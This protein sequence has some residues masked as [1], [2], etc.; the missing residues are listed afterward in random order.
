MSG[1]PAHNACLRWTCRADL[2]V[3]AQTDQATPRSEDQLNSLWSR[4][5]VQTGDPKPPGGMGGFEETAASPHRL[6]TNHPGF[7]EGKEEAGR[8]PEQ[9][10]LLAGRSIANRH[11]A[12]SPVHQAR[13]RSHFQRTIR[14]G[15]G[16]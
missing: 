14:G 9:R 3:F 1:G 16:E 10:P 11:R 5:D 8:P 6:F 4:A 2:P 15:V 12:S 7:P 13:W